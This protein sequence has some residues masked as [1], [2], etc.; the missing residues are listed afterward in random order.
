MSGK[1]QAGRQDIDKAREPWETTLQ[2]GLGRLGQPN[3]NDPCFA[4]RDG[5]RSACQ[6]VHEGCCGDGQKVALN[7]GREHQPLK[8]PHVL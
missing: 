4:S 2:S 8:V 6:P 7:C 5:T 1:A 3:L